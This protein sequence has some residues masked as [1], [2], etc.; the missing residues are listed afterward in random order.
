M[1]LTL[2]AALLVGAGAAHAANICQADANDAF[3]GKYLAAAAEAQRQSSHD[4]MGT[5]ARA[6]TKWA[7]AKVSQ[8]LMPGSHDAGTFGQPNQILLKAAGSLA[9]TQSYSLLDQLCLGGRWFDVRLTPVGKEWRINHNFY[10]FGLASNVIEQYKRFIE[11]PAHADEF[12]FVRLKLE[13]ATPEQKAAMYRQWVDALKDH[14]VKSNGKGFAD[15]TTAQIKAAA[16][17]AGGRILLLEYDKEGPSGVPDDLKDSFFD[18]TKHQTG[19]FSDKIKFA[20]MEPAQQAN[21]DG[22]RGKAPFG[23]WWTSTGKLPSYDVRTNTKPFWPKA[24][25][26]PNTPL[27]EF[28]KKNGC[29]VGTFLVVDFYGDV[30]LLGQRTNTILDLAIDHNLKTLEGKKPALC[31]S[32]AKAKQ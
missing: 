29:S 16:T 12:V 30:G 22:A 11:D 15:L 18:Y 27:E 21:L 5:S 24:K 32:A 19:T 4:W 28:V 25:A 23:L 20:E 17:G 10:H 2:L 31:Q 14:L 7:S 3:K 1:K 13:K 6:T 9:R 26:S 8:L